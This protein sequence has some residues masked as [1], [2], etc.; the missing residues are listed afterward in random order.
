MKN[1]WIGRTRA[2]NRQSLNNAG[3]EIS[4]FSP[5]QERRLQARLSRIHAIDRHEIGV[6]DEVTRQGF[7]ASLRSPPPDVVGYRLL[8]WPGYVE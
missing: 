7:D 3:H 6:A 8:H 4:E 5:V 1:K 2:D